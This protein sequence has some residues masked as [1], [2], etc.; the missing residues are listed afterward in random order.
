MTHDLQWFIDRIG[1]R[2]FRDKDISSYICSCDICKNIFEKGLIILDKEHAQYLFD[3]QNETGIR[4][5]EKT[6]ENLS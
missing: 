3:V 2:V 4:Y 6:H 1:K 5:Y